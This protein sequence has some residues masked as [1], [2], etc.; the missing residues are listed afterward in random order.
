[1]I[2]LK[3]HFKLSAIYTFFAALPAL[4]QLIVYPIIEGEARLDASDFGLLAITEAITSAVF[5]L[6]TFGMLR[7]LSRFYY[8]YADSRENYNKLVSTV[9]S[10][11]IGRGLLLMGIVIVF[12]PFIGSLFSQPDL[13]N[14]TAYGP[15]IV[16]SGFN[17]AIVITLLALYRHEKRLRIFILVSLFS[18]ILRAGFQLMGVL[19]YDMSFLGYVHGTAVGSSLV[20]IVIVGYS[21]YKCGF[22]YNKNIRRSLFPFISPLFFSDLIIWGLLFADRFFLLKNPGELGIYD[23]A[24]KFAIGIELILQ[25]LSNAIQPEVY[26]YLKEGVE[27]KASEIKTLCNLFI[28]E[29]IGIVVLAILP[30]MLFITLFYETELRLSAGLFTIVFTRFILTSQYRVFA[31]PVLFLK[32]TKL[33]FYIN[34]C[35]LILNI[36]LNWIL[37]PLIGYYGAITAFFSAYFIQVL[38][39]YIMQQKIIQ[40]N[41]NKY[42]IL[43]LPLGIV[44]MAI[45]LEIL[46]LHFNVDPFLTSVIFVLVSLT[47]L[48]LL[49]RKELKDYLIM[50]YKE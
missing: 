37:T 17:R 5:I 2:N 25:G 38:L 42:K 48:T 18:G 1:M 32:K 12:G 39:F 36:G 24:M 43:Y 8:D 3:E 15:S 46:K 44:F 22:H 20:A 33:F 16:L 6:C 19:L 50:R 41:W 9:I 30:A 28:A 40:I 7:G 21:Y 11:I 31:M 23:N 35:I 45:A 14:F 13:Q 29:S 4:L 26:R 10:G 34:S 49:Y 27:R 47:S